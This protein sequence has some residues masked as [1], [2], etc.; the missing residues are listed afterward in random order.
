ALLVLCTSLFFSLSAQAAEENA[1][2]NVTGQSTIVIDR[3][4]GEVLF[5]HDPDTRRPMASTTKIM[6][7]FLALK[8]GNLDDEVT[9]SAKAS[10]IYGSRIYLDEGERQTLEDL[11]YALMLSSANDAA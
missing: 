3:K 6:T 1:L 2:G 8:H 11:L 7:A 10:Q 5:S 9:V 4:T